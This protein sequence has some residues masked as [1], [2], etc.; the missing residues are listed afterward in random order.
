MAPSEDH[1]GVWFPPPLI[2]V[3]G[4]LLGALLEALVSIGDMPST[5]AVILGPLLIAA[6]LLFLV[7]A[8]RTF[9][10]ARTT[11]VTIK[12]AATLVTGG[13]YRFTRN[14]MYVGL[15]LTYAGLAVWLNLIWGL[16]LLPVV[17]LVVD[18]Y[19]ISREERYL[20]RAFGQQYDDYA[21][22]VRRWL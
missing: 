9:K 16:I 17:L 7:P 10:E 4:F 18:R 21:G 5:L 12:P 1:P 22:R 13:P 11:V 8:W 20:R 6:G 2:Y 3:G 19:V 15:A 14:P